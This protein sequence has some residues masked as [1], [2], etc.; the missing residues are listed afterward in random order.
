MWATCHVGIG[1]I[2]RYKR[3]FFPQPI[4]GAHEKDQGKSKRPE[5]DPVCGIR[6]T[7]AELMSQYCQI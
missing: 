6:V 2:T 7:L 4:A 3:K 5:R 1:R